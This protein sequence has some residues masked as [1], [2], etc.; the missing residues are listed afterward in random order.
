MLDVCAQHRVQG[1]SLQDCYG[2]H[3]VILYLAAMIFHTMPLK[4]YSLLRRHCSNLGMQ[5]R[6][7]DI[8][9]LHTDLA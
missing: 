9:S 5:C 6:M 8:D 4:R 3:L 7:P 2:Q 1:A